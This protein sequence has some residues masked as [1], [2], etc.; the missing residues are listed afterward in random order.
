MAFDPAVLEVARGDTVI[1]INHDIVPH[2]TAATG[3]PGWDTG[4]LTRGQEGRYV[5]RRGGKVPYI[6]TLHP[7]MRG[8]LIIR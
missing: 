7:T 6:C 1:W 4:T 8:I 5:P 2:A 3:S